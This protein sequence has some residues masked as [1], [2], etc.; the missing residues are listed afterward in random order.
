METGGAKG[1][2]LCT[3]T[4]LSVHVPVVYTAQLHKFPLFLV[5]VFTVT[6]RSIFSC[7][8]TTATDISSTIS[9][10]QGLENYPD[11]SDL[12]LDG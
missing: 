11:T 9:H 6:L 7:Q 12:S 4:A 10:L 8:V 1:H 2:V 3:G 5:C